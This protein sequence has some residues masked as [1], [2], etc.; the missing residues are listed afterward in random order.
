M[1]KQGFIGTNETHWNCSEYETTYFYAKEEQEDNWFNYGVQLSLES[2]D[3]ALGFERKGLKRVVLVLDS[4]VISEFGTLSTDTSC[5]NMDHCKQFE[6][7]IPIHC[8][9]QIFIDKTEKDL[10]LLYYLGMLAKFSEDHIKYKVPIRLSY[11]SE[12]IEPEILKASIGVY[13]SLNLWY[14]EEFNAYTL[15]LVQEWT[16][17]Q[18]RTKEG[19]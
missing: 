7:L 10:F 6:G 14:F 5:E 9:E 17:A 18:F 13:E 3:I 16:L 2:G 15:D 12:G 4:D 1:V 8:V 11:F 19:L